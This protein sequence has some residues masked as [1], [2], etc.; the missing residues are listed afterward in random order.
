M[1]GGSVLGGATLGLTHNPRVEIFL[2]LLE[3]APHR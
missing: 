2:E 1:L 3:I